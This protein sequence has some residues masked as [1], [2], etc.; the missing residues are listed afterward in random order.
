[1]HYVIGLL[2]SIQAFLIVVQI[3]AYAVGHP[4][5]WWFILLPLELLVAV[6]VLFWG[7]LGGLYAKFS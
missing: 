3:C 5:S 2:G 7:I 6:A 4:F 1:M